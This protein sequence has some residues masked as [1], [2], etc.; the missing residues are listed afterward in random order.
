M[1]RLRIVHETIY[2]YKR[3]V[4]FGPHRIILRPREGHDVRVEEMRLDISP[5]FELEWSR[6]LFG[7]SIATARFLNSSDHLQIRSEVF[8]DQTPSFPLPSTRPSTLVPFPVQF[9]E[10]ESEIAAAY[11]ATIFPR[12]VGQVK[13]WLRSAVDLTALRGAEDVVAAVARAI[14]STIQY[15]RREAKGVQAPATTLGEQSGSC[16]DMATLML[17]A[18]RALGL[19][20]RFASG[21][22]DCLA[23]EAGRGAM[24]AWSEAYLPEIGWLGYDPTLGEATSLK[25][26]LTGVSNHPQGVMPVSGTFLDEKEAYL[27][28]KVTV[29]TERLPAGV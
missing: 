11:Q 15:R 24:H 9:S 26:V 29:L 23:T 7:N 20:A 27:E 13:E 12:D 18:L 10:L 2:T 14:R 28:M 21:Y 16:R 22:L 3:P 8:L 6:D 17:E 25:H 5:E 4:R 19:P 1:S